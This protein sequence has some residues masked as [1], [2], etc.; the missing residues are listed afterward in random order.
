MSKKYIPT[1]NFPSKRARFSAG[2]GAGVSRS[3]HGRQ[4]QYQLWDAVGR[5]SAFDNA[6]VGTP[7]CG[8][9]TA[10]RA[11]PTKS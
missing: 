1:R 3:G 5:K 7:R 4:S 6:L 9:R 8:V 11:V 2:S 10:Q